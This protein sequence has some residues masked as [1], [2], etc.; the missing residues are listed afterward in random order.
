MEL[1]IPKPTAGQAT[2]LVP[3]ARPSSLLV[4]S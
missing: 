2:M 4:R 3:Q 1:A